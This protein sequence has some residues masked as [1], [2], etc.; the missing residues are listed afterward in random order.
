MLAS[1]GHGGS[2]V[3]VDVELGPLVYLWLRDLV[4]DCGDEAGVVSR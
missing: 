4:T 2:V 1:F 3:G